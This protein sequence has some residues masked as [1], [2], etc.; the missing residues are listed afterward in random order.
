MG[1]VAIDFKDGCLSVNSAFALTDR[2]RGTVVPSTSG[3]KLGKFVDYVKTNNKLEQLEHLGSEDAP[4]PPPPPTPP[5][6][7]LMIT[8]STESYWIPSQ[9]KTKSKLQI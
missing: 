5:P 2:K 4:P 7:H 8:H 9:K 3:G 6:H 1:P